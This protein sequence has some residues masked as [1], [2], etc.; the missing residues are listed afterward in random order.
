MSCREALK[1]QL[2]QL[3]ATIT[4]N[5]SETVVLNRQ[6]GDALTALEFT[7]T[8]LT[9]RAKR[10]SELSS[11]TG[12]KDKT[13][14][15]LRAEVDVLRQRLDAEDNIRAQLQVRAQDSAPSV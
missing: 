11:E 2:A 14:A 6:L 7:N 13:I 10:I 12:A 8:E 15:S 1:A 4:L 3:E 9:D 5:R